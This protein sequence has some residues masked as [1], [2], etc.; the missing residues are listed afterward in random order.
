EHVFVLMLENRSYDHVFGFGP[1]GDLKGDESN[2]WQGQTL[3]FASGADYAMPRDPGHSFTDVLEQLAGEGAAYTRGRPYPPIT[4]S[5]FAS[6][7]G[8]YEPGAV[9]SVFKGFTPDQL[10]VLSFLARN[11]CVC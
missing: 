5:G 7:F 6:N 11:Y 8:G 2:L 1:A 10:P 4:M 9:A 3:R